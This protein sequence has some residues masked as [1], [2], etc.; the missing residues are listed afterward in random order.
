MKLGA[1]GPNGGTGLLV[2]SYEADKVLVYSRR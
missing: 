1:V 2:T